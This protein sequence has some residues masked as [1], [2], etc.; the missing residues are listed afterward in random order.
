MDTIY[1]W[2]RIVAI[3]FVVFLFM[4]TSLPFVIVM[5]QGV[6][7]STVATLV[8]S[9]IFLIPLFFIA[10]AF[11]FMHKNESEKKKR[12]GLGIM[13]IFIVLLIGYSFFA[14]HQYQQHLAQQ[15]E[16]VTFLKDQSDKNKMAETL[17][18]MIE[19]AEAQNSLEQ[20][21]INE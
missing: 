16:A 3:V 4:V 10:L 2:A 19:Q 14:E 20:K 9:V 7:S 5:I 21:R 17:K 15:T 11:R 18:Y 13:I 8:T 12:I 6:D 1:K